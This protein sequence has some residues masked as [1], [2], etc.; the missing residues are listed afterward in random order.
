MIAS[1]VTLVST[2]RLQA[3]LDTILA[4]Y[5]ENE[6]SRNIHVHLPGALHAPAEGDSGQAEFDPLAAGIHG[7]YSGV[8]R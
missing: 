5:V 8:V 2:N 3:P 1:M 4:E 6:V 7:A